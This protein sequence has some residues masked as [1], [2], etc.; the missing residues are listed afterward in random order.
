MLF[1]IKMTPKSMLKK[2]FRV[3]RI[4]YVPIRQFRN[5]S[6]LFHSALRTM[7]F[8]GQ[9]GIGTRFMLFQIKVRAK[10]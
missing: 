6:F 5:Q 2:I 9:L 1:F 3:F 10:F 8:Y 7:Y 4:I